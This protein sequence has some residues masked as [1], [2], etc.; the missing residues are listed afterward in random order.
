MLVTPN[1]QLAAEF[2]S[3][4][5]RD[6]DSVQ[7]AVR[8]CP[9]VASLRQINDSL[10]RLTAQSNSSVSEIS[11]VISRDM[12]MTARLLRLV[13]SVFTGLSVHVT[14]V[15][16][17]IFYLGLRQIRQLALTARIV[18]ETRSFGCDDVSDSVDWA[19]FWR[20]SI[21]CGILSREILSMAS[22]SMD[23]DVYY[24]SG[25]MQ[26]VGK[27]V[28][29]NI[30]P[31]ELAQRQQLVAGS[32]EELA[33][34]EYESY[35]WNHAQIGAL[36]L[37]SNNMPQPVVEAV[38][39]QF[40]PSRAASGAKLAAGVQLA[41]TI[42]RYGG[43]QASFENT[44]DVEYEDWEQL[45]GWEILFGTDKAE[46]QYARATILSCVERLPIILKGLL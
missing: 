17:A 41:E 15:D 13:N 44:N 3:K 42:A 24:I 37:E 10:N 25:L 4:E 22:G 11:E 46:R 34:L 39:F 16:E 20:H 26:D 40:E 33:L 6:F 28:M 45:A 36:Y 7:A 1:S 21:G 9:P 43:C 19:Q 38:L 2:C 8:A 29:F 5:I 30:F 23:D 32:R 27:L 35:G 12:S 31:A 14:S 18:E